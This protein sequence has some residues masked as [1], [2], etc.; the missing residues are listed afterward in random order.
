L[1]T[2]ELQLYDIHFRLNGS[3]SVAGTNEEEAIKL[4]WERHSKK[5]IHQAIRVRNLTSE[6]VDLAVE[7][8]SLSVLPKK[9]RLFGK[10]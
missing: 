7:S 10:A 5:I 2:Q 1:K 8:V 6:G 9:R 3:V 4:F